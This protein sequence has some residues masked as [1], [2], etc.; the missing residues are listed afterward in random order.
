MNLELSNDA[1][2][3][4]AAKALAAQ[5]LPGSRLVRQRSAGWG[6]GRRSYLFEA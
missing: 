4:A 3:E 2:Y 5:V 1:N 6:I